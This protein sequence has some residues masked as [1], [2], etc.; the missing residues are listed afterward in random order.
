[1]AKGLRRRKPSYIPSR[2]FALTVLDTFAPPTGGTESHDLVQRARDALAAD[3]SGES[4]GRALN[5][6][7]KGL[8][9]DA[10]EEARLAAGPANRRGPI[11]TAAQVYEALKQQLPAISPEPTA[12]GSSSSPAGR[13]T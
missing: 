10:L 4:A 5:S 9:R 8:L 11:E 1:M 6:R 12:S 7:V 2:T 3:E 13:R